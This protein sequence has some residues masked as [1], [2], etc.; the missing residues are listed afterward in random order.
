MRGV[1]FRLSR[2]YKIA[3]RCQFHQQNAV[4]GHHRCATPHFENGS[5]GAFGLRPNMNNIK[6]DIINLEHCTDRKERVLN[7]LEQIDDAK[8]DEANIFKAHRDEDNGAL[9]CAI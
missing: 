7:S 1:S 8:I 9:G 6:I 5:R 3:F 2:A 4:I